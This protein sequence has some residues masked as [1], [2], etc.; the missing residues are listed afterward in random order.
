MK[1]GLVLGKFLPLHNGSVTLCNVAGTLSDKLIIV[2][3]KLPEDAIPLKLRIKWLKKEFPNAIVTQ[4]TWRSTSML[5]AKLVFEY[6][7]RHRFGSTWQLS[8]C[9]GKGNCSKR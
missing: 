2:V 7:V 3:L 6:A 8:I 4:A 1:L 9:F 5:E